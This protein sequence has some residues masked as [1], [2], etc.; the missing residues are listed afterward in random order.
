MLIC[1][2]SQWKLHVKCGFQIPI[3]LL[4]NKIDIMKQICSLYVANS[5]TELYIFRNW[6]LRHS[7]FTFCLK[8]EP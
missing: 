8:L 4:L 7:R 5:V 6:V 3:L 1:D 2:V